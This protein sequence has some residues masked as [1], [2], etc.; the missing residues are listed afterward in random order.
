MFFLWFPEYFFFFDM[1]NFSMGFP[2]DS[3]VKNPPASASEAG[4]IPE[5]ERSLK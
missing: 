2:V 5:S 4:L 3:V 1:Y